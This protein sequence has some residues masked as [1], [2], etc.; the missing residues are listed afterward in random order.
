MFKILILLDDPRIFFQRNCCFN[1][2]SIIKNKGP[3]KEYH[4]SIPAWKG[5][6][7]CALIISKAFNGKATFMTHKL[8][9]LEKER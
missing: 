8:S 7:F 4:T 9:N 1:T 6:T 5:F 3:L 2:C